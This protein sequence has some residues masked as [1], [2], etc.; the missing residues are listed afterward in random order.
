MR[1]ESNLSIARSKHIEHRDIVGRAT[2]YGGGDGQLRASVS[3]KLLFAAGSQRESCL[4]QLVQARGCGVNCWRKHK[5][6]QCVG[7]CKS[8]EDAAEVNP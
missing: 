1:V 8:C 2:G 6:T 7:I 3:T 5:D 4:A